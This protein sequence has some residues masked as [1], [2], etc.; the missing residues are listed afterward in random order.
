M[1]SPKRLFVGLCMA[2]WLVNM[3]MTGHGI[4]D[5]FWTG[6]IESLFSVPVWT[7]MGTLVSGLAVFLFRLMKVDVSTRLSLWQK[8]DVGL[9]MALIFKPTLG[10]PF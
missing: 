9:A 3:L 2:V 5:D 4:T 6:L 10:I 8:A 1:I 7:L